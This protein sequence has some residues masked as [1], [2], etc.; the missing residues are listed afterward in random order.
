MCD[1]FTPK[2]VLYIVFQKALNCVMYTI[3][4]HTHGPHLLASLYSHKCS[5]LFLMAPIILIFIFNRLAKELIQYM[6]K[7]LKLFALCI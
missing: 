6:K 5:T 3:M 7:N 4:L 2:R 1:L